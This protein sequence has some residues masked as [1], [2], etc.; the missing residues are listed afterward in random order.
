MFLGDVSQSKLHEMME[1]TTSMDPY[2]PTSSCKSVAGVKPFLGLSQYDSGASVQRVN[3]LSIFSV[4]LMAA[5]A[6]KF[7]N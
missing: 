3:F 6:Q 2:S 7:L 1:G 4:T 5:A